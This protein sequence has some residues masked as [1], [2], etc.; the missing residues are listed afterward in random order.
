MRSFPVAYRNPAIPSPK[1]VS[2]YEHDAGAVAAAAVVV[3][4]TLLAVVV[5]AVL[6]D[7]T[8]GG[9]HASVRL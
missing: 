3:T 4:V 1:L 9:R 5:V 7:A 8:T 2:P 6:V